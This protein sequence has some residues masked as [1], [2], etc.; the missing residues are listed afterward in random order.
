MEMKRTKGERKKIRKKMAVGEREREGQAG[1]WKVLWREG[2]FMFECR[3]HSGA[4]PK[5]KFGARSE[6]EEESCCLEDG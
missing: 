6:R 5:R 1:R 4:P 2:V 3:Q